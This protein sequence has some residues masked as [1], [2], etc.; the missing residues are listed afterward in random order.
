MITITVCLEYSV[1]SPFTCLLGHGDGHGH[2]EGH[3]HNDHHGKLGIFFY[4]DMGQCVEGKMMEMFEV[5]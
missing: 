2:K 5:Y 1:V 4:C 3:H